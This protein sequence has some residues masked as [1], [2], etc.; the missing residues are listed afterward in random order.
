VSRGQRRRLAT[1]SD[2]PARA[3]PV[4]YSPAT[5]F[6]AVFPTAPSGGDAS[7]KGHSVETDYN[8]QLS[9]DT[10]LTL[11]DGRVLVVR[12]IEDVDDLHRTHRLYCEEV[13]N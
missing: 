12:G 10:R 9:I 2:T 8:A 4:V 11:D 7:A 3:T 13:I 1:L 5:V 6:V